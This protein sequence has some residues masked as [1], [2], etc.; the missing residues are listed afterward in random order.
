MPFG[1]KSSLPS[2][3]RKISCD[4]PSPSKPHLQVFSPSILRI[5]VTQYPQQAGLPPLL[6]PAPS[7]LLPRLF[8]KLYHLPRAFQLPLLLANCSACFRLC[9][10]LGRVPDRP[11]LPTSPPIPLTK[12]LPPFPLSL[13]LSS[14]CH[15]AFVMTY[16]LVSLPGWTSTAW[17]M[18][19]RNP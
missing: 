16:L 7:S 1:I 14:T 15:T 12:W 10:P 3:I 13:C 18:C 11:P 5:D 19:Y 9:L 6:S 8:H 4:L 17:L 2:I